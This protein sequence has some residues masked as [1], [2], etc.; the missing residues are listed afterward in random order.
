[1]SRT[2][3]SPPWRRAARPRRPPD[4]PPGSRRS[5]SPRAGV[6]ARRSVVS[7][8][9]ASAKRPTGCGRHRR[10]RRRRE[11]PHP[12]AD[13][14]IL[15]V[16]LVRDQPRGDVRNDVE[17]GCRQPLGDVERWVEPARRRGS[18]GD[19]RA[20]RKVPHGLLDHALERDE[21]E[22]RVLEQGGEHVGLPLFEDVHGAERM[23]RI[24]RR[25]RP[26][27]PRRARLPAWASP[28]PGR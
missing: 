9:S 5:R 17:A 10:P 8:P 16:L 25:G 21:L 1:M 22:P 20:L 28:S 13:G 6:R 23:T 19:L 12:R 27:Q 11:R 2:A 15:G 18:D 7:S 24:S 26:P 3:P 4:A 14:G